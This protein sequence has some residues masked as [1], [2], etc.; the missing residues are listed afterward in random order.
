MCVPLSSGLVAVLSPFIFFFGRTVV[1]PRI[2]ASSSVYFGSGH[3]LN[4]TEILYPDSEGYMPEYAHSAPRVSIVNRR[5]LLRGLLQALVS[6]KDIYRV[7]RASTCLHICVSSQYLDLV[8]NTWLPDWEENGWPTGEEEEDEMAT[9]R[10]RK[11]ASSVSTRNSTNMSINGR[12]R[13][14]SRLSLRRQSAASGADSIRSGISEMSG[15]T[16]IFAMTG[17]AQLIYDE[18]SN[19]LINEDLL[20]KI[21]VFR[22][23]FFRNTNT[24][25]AAYIQL[26]NCRQNPADKLSKEAVKGASLDLTTQLPRARSLSLFES[27][28]SIRNNSSDSLRPASLIGTS[29]LK[30]PSS[31]YSLSSPTK[32]STPMLASV[33]ESRE[34]AVSR[35]APVIAPLVAAPAIAS[36]TK[37]ASAPKV[38][39]PVAAPAIVPSPTAPIVKQPVQASKTLSKDAESGY[40]TETDMDEFDDAASSFSNDEE[41]PSQSAI[42][43]IVSLPTAVVAAGVAAVMAPSSE[44]KVE[45]KS[46]KVAGDDAVVAPSSEITAEKSKSSSRLAKAEPVASNRGSFAKETKAALTAVKVTNNDEVVK[47]I[48]MPTRASSTHRAKS[49]PVEKNSTSADVQRKSSIKAQP[50]AGVKREQSTRSRKSVSVEPTATTRANDVKREP[51]A[52]STTRRSAKERTAIVPPPLPPPAPKQRGSSLS[53]RRKSKSSKPSQTKRSS[54]DPYIP[55]MDR[56]IDYRPQ[57]NRNLRNGGPTTSEE[58]KQITSS[59]LS[60]PTEERPPPTTAQSVSRGGPFSFFRKRP[61]VQG[62]F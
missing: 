19:R 14:S 8:W 30:K 23:N 54:D 13:A 46:S 55:P 6:V 18:D 58:R 45:V 61:S 22:R 35:A 59:I 44:D 17:D 7:G 20:R 26:I 48:P 15:M 12:N 38:A 34:N 25:G 56:L 47:P 3:P 21:A 39:P 11:R 42:G 41:A 1:A 49:A 37:T 62:V 2:I 40:G 16:G 9:V 5:S 33:Q 4:R 43:K 28:G 50:A 27:N 60:S 31:I 24:K 57:K 36:K 32:K 29:R 10:A 52:R 53:L 51:S